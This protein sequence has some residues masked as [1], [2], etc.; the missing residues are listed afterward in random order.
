MLDYGRDIGGL[1]AVLECR[2]GLWT[3]SFQRSLPGELKDL[4]F[5]KR[6]PAKK[7]RLSP[8]DKKHQNKNLQYD[9]FSD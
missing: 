9:F 8:N 2:C 7:T 4:A 5:S 3:Q 6:V 1:L